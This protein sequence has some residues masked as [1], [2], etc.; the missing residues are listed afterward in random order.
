MKDTDNLE[1]LLRSLNL[2]S[3]VRNYKE[4]A[5]KSHKQKLTTR[6]CEGGKR[7]ATNEEG[8]K[9]HQ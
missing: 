2:K 5:E 9:T 6:A 1:A 3:F 7:G 8:R 4:F